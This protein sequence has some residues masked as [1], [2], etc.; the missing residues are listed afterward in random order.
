MDHVYI[1]DLRIACI[2]GIYDWERQVRQQLSL[3]VE[4]A[5]DIA[6]AARSGAIEDAIDYAAMAE[7]ITDFVVAGEF[8]LLETLAE[9]TAQMLL[10]EFPV[11][12]LRLRVGKPG[13]VAAAGD[14]GVVIERGLAPDLRT[15]S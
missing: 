6:A 7:R 1:R 2:I 9:E 8:Q 4:V 15:P 11:S 5:S 13:A 14:V 10:Q 3:D 12:W